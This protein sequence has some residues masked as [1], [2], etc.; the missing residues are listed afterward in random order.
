MNMPQTYS[1]WTIGCQMNKAESRHLA[2]HLENAGYI[3]TPTFKK[4]DV[5]IL[6][7]C[8]V[9]QNAED[10]VTGMLS[11]LK[12]MKKINPDLKI[13]V[14]GCFVDSN[15]TD[16]GKKYPYV[17]VF[18]KPGD[19]EAFKDWGLTIDSFSKTINRNVSPCTAMI[20]IIEGCNNYCTYCI[21]PYRRGHE[22]SKPVKTILETAKD[23]VDKGASEIVLLGQ[24]V[25]S[26]GHD[27]PDH[28]E[29]SHLLEELHGIE[30]LLRIRFLTNHPKD[31]NIRLI[32]TI[33]SLPKVCKHLN[34]PLQAGDDD[35]L[36]AMGR[37][38][39]A[40]HYVNLVCKIRLI[41]PAIALS[42]DII[43][44]FPG[45]TDQKF[46]NTMSILKEIKFDTV[47]VA[48]YSPRAGTNAAEKLADDVPAEIKRQ[49]L[50]TI[51]QL[52]SAI[53]SDINNSYLGRKVPVLV[54]G[55]KKNKWFGRTE[56]DKLVFFES[57][58]DLFNQIVDVTINKAGTWSLQGTI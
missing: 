54:E 2:D 51:E 4:A 11:Y 40:S 36:A 37:Y 43:V 41:I 45:E 58:R 42:T 12:G 15:I 57:E 52:Q 50:Q 56:T 48:T 49:R 19:F 44:G 34:L 9:R 7:T 10:K 17:N 26:Y 29:L 24:N 32:E 5:V 6:N 20:P 33:A 31:M 13:I 22:R 21:V 53:V 25:N 39:K 16:L 14:T 28:P 3:F 1:I 35:I 30:K 18:F 38:Y 47:H 55:K 23:F 46:D 8:V 27:L